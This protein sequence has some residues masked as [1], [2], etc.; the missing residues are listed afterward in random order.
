M[1]NDASSDISLHHTQSEDGVIVD[2]SGEDVGL[3]LVLNGKRTPMTLISPPDSHLSRLAIKSDGPD[4][5]V[6][7]YGPPIAEITD[8]PEAPVDPVLTWLRLRHRPNGWR[9]ILDGLFDLNLPANSS[10]KPTSG[11]VELRAPFGTID[12]ST[13]AAA[14]S[15]SHDSSSLRFSTTPAVDEADAY[16]R[17]VVVIHKEKAKIK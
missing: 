15:S 8:H 3:S 5:I 10:V 13:E 2:Y 16:P 11:G 7:F 14:T 9:V 17:S 6:R 1:I 12:Y 4:L